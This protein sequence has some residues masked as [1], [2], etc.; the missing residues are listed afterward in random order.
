MLGVRFPD[1][2]PAGILSVY[3]KLPPLALGIPVG[4]DSWANG[5]Q[6]FSKENNFSAQ[7]Q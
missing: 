4:T 3:G 6:P 7:T 1:P 5:G 2:E